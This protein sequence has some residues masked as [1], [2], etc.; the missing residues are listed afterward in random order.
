M[1]SFLAIRDKRL[2]GGVPSRPNLGIVNLDEHTSLS[3]AFAAVRGCAG[4]GKVRVAYV[5]CHGFAGRDYSARV[6]DDV[7]GMGLELGREF[8][9]SF[10]R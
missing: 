5:F 2:K 9:P 6:S 8:G 10:Q 7:G 4:R 1:P 3:K